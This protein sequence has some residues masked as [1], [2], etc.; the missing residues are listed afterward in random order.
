MIAKRMKNNIKSGIKEA[1]LLVWIS[2]LPLEHFFLFL[3]LKFNGF[4]Y[5]WFPVALIVVWWVITITISHFTDKRETRRQEE[6]REK[7]ITQITLTDERF[8]SLVFDYDSLED[9]LE[10]SPCDLPPF[11]HH[12]PDSLTVQMDGDNFTDLT[13]TL[14]T[15]ALH[16]IYAREEEIINACCESVKETYDDEEIRDGQGALITMAFIREDFGVTGFDISIDRHGRGVTAEIHGGM[17]SS[18]H[19]HIDEHGV[20]HEIELG[21]RS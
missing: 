5:I 7:Y 4:S 1:L 18:F 10:A 9:R 3:W 20:T 19:D 16:E 11:G 14:V 13:L 17:N 12:R 8:G 2:L 15:D 6:Y 21:V